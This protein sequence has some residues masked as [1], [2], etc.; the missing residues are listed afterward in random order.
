M[1]FHWVT[2][3]S[4]SQDTEQR[5]LCVLTTEP[6]EVTLQCESFINKRVKLK[7]TFHRSNYNLDF[8]LDYK[9]LHCSIEWCWWILFLGWKMLLFKRLE[10]VSNFQSQQTAVWLIGLLIRCGNKIKAVP[11]GLCLHI[12]VSMWDCDLTPKKNVIYHSC[13]TL[14]VGKG[15]RCRDAGIFFSYYKASIS[16]SALSS[17]NAIAVRIMVILFLRL[18]NSQYNNH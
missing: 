10:T 9:Q 2:S 7:T 13:K 1:P 18:I 17:P 15:E 5:H 3:V 16:T 11:L 6:R 12:C 8:T 4:A 14:E